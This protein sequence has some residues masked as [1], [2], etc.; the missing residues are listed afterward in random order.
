MAL[1]TLHRDISPISTPVVRVEA[2]T[3]SD[4]DWQTIK[5]VSTPPRA[6]ISNPS[7]KK[8]KEDRNPTPQSHQPQPIE[9]PKKKPIP[10]EMELSNPNEDWDW[11]D[12]DERF[13]LRPANSQHK[14]PAK[15]KLPPKPKNETVVAPVSPVSPVSVQCGVPKSAESVRPAVF[16]TAIKKADRSRLSDLNSPAKPADSPNLGET[17]KAGTPR[18]AGNDEET[19]VSSDDAAEEEEEFMVVERFNSEEAFAMD[20]I[21]GK[22]EMEFEIESGEEKLLEQESD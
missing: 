8:N 22:E 5:V 18:T 9:T 1:N 11:S 12:S 7:T 3:D 14:A 21:P 16:S 4:D 17:P 13:A 2:I 6:V 15:S 10:A 20:G 19:F